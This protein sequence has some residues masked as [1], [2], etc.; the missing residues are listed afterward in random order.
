F[1]M[2]EVLS[3]CPTNWGLNPQEALNWLQENMIPQYP[4]GITKEGK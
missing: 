4:L 3:T 1:T 2:V